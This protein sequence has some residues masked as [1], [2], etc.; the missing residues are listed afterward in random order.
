MA[1][2]HMLEAAAVCKAGLVDLSRS[3]VARQTAGIDATGDHPV[4]EV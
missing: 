1:E 3:V 2:L 4:T